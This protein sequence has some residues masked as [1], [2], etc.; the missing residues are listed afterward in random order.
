M[1]QIDKALKDFNMIK[2][3]SKIVVGFSGGAD[4]VTL[5]HYLKCKLN[6]DV[7]ACHINHNLRG[8]ES[9][10]DQEFVKEFC[11]LYDIP[12]YVKSGDIKGY[13][14][15][16][17]MTIEEA[18]REIR[19]GYFNEIMKTQNADCIATA[20]TLSD[21][22]ETV[23]LNMTRG[24]GLSG[25]CG[26]PPVRGKVI[27]PLIYCTRQEI[28]NY[29]ENNNLQYVIDSTNNDSNY[30][31]NNIR[32]NVIP[33]LKQINKSFEK[34][35]LRNT[36]ILSSD[37]DCLRE[38]ANNVILQS[39]Q[40][41]GYAIGVIKS[42]HVAIRHR[43]I[44]SFLKENQINISADLIKRI[45]GMIIDSKGKI[46]ISVLKYIEIKDN[47]L[48]VITQKKP[49][50]Y[51]EDELKLGEYISK[52]G[53]KFKIYKN[54]LLSIKSTKKVYKNLLYIVMD[55]DKIKGI[56]VIRQ[57][58]Q[59]DK[60]EFVNRTG[61]RLL[62]KLFIDQKLSAYEKSKTLVLSDQE[63]VISVFPFGVAKRVAVDEKTQNVLVIER[64]L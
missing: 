36:E 27:R 30:S 11:K 39:K 6:L 43:I 1:N 13:A 15:K 51:F 16:N 2:E 54:N 31:R 62:K 28:E 61:T 18:G 37:R 20:H 12:I 5:S 63:G 29:C 35:V 21:N 47:L 45:D 3:H 4:S 26:I 22:A 42:Q 52:A 48:T 57:R 55:Y 50:E 10:R 46:N 41:N 25:L 56:T 9:M 23:L 19:Y 32:N 17:S 8:N 58:K 59:S 24:A 53:E 34:V 7:V 40:E 60:I 49:V 33:V 38:I 44:S 64:I 14:I